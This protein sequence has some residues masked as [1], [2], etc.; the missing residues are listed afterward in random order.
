M[1]YAAGAG[2]S[3]VVAADMNNDG[4]LDLAV[5][6]FNASTVTV[7]LNNGSGAFTATTT[8]GVGA[9]PFYIEAGDFDG[10]GKI[11]LVTANS[12]DGT[13]SVL[14]GTGGGALATA[15]PYN[16]GSFP[17]SIA[18]ADLNGDHVLDLAVGND[19][20]NDVGVLFGN[21]DGTFQSALSVNSGA[22][23][24]N[25]VTVADF[26]GDG[27]L[28]IATGDQNSSQI[29]VILGHLA[30]AVEG[31]T[32]SGT[33]ATFTTNDATAMAGWFSA[34]INWGD[35]NT[36]TGLVSANG[37]GGFDVAGSH[38]YSEEGPYTIQVTVSGP[39]GATASITNNIGVADAP[40]VGRHHL[41]LDRGA[42]FGAVATYRPG[43][44]RHRTT[45]HHRQGDSHLNG[46]VTYD[47]RPA[48]SSS[49]HLRG[50]GQTWW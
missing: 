34:S 2:A 41:Q 26:N 46:T 10:D 44:R 38:L 50:G 18:L 48:T 16:V 6:N 23:G 33:V 47:A 27:K 37:S 14:Q 30:S 4:T 25:G 39:A 24:V 1:N 42:A 32:F 28:D 7:F 40:A 35:G 45:R 31:Q 17:D 19:N 13:I 22:G 5:A 15:T 49:A 20:S 3:A 36:T 8:A 43:R 9:N 11:D 29:S 12:G 21:E